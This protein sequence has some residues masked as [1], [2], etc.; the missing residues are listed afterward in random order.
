M[1][2]AARVAGWALVAALAAA[3][4]VSARVFW[5]R[6]GAG[7]HGVASAGQPGWDLAWR[8]QVRI[9]G[10]AGTLE[11]LGTLSGPPETARQ[12][13]A[14]Y[15][16]QGGPSVAFSAAG[17]AWGM[18]WVDGRIVR[19][20]A[21]DAGRVRE[22]VVFRLEQTPEDFRASL[23]PPREHAI[24]DVPVPPGAR[25]RQVLANEDRGLVMEQ[26]VVSAGAAETEAWMADAMASLGWTPVAPGGA[27]RAGG[28]P[29]AWY[30]RGRVTALVHVTPDAAGGARVLRVRRAE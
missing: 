19:W 24:G 4:P 13:N 8:A 6:G 17:M 10:G 26:S 29:P 21:A 27:V 11:A 2:R 28:R 16:A 22:S 20:L 30:R 23:Q 25:V 14:V 1:N 7:A 5:R 3:A 12:L 15:R 9:N 18:A